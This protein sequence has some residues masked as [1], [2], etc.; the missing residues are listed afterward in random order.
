MEGYVWYYNSTPGN[1]MANPTSPKTPNHGN[2][3]GKGRYKVSDGSQYWLGD[4]LA[5]GVLHN[6]LP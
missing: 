6:P 1:Y 5:S 4:S 3:Y 2:Y